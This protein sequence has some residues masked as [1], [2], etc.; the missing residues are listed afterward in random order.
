MVSMVLNI[1]QIPPL[2]MELSALEYMYL[3]YGCIPFILVAIDL[4]LFEVGGYKD[5]L[6]T[7]YEFIFLPDH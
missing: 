5:T 7:L 4:I 2:T 3:K 1:G 6:S